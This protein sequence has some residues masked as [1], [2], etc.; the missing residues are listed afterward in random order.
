MSEFDDVDETDGEADETGAADIEV[1]AWC[2]AGLVAF[3]AAA[4]LDFP[5]ELSSGKSGLDPGAFDPGGQEVVPA[6][7]VLSVPDEVTSQ[8]AQSLSEFDETPSAA[9]PPGSIDEALDA[10]TYDEL[11][12]AREQLVVGK[13]VSNTKASS[14]A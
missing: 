10:M 4:G 13:E 14:M 5:D 11:V 2:V 1:G 12:E 7:Q 6:N 8:A 9:P 3:D